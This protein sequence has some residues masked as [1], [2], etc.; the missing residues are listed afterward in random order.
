MIDPTVFNNVKYVIDG[1]GTKAAVQLDISL[2][3]SLLA[4]IEDL[5]D[6]SLVKDK[7]ARL[8]QGPEKSGSVPWKDVREE[9]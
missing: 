6:R 7:L 2:W 8:I 1:N 9:W 3:E 5:E 4:Y